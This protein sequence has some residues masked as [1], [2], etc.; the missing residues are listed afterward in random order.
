MSDLYNESNDE[1]P[2]WSKIYMDFA[3]SLSERSSCDRASVGCVITSKDHHRVLAIG[4]NGNYR[5]G[6]NCCDTK[7]PGSC[8]CI[9][10]ESNAIVK[11]D[12]NDL[13]EK[14]LY[15]T[16]SP[17]YACAKLIIQANIQEV[18]YNILYR[19]QEGIQLLQNNRIVVKQWGRE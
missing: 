19:K 6:P 16:T 7:K 12:Y 3:F 10:S 18:R 8:G 15:T 11:M 2:G 13:S 17:C 14:I 1:R 5:G 4:Y 9:H